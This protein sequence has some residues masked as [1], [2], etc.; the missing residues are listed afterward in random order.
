MLRQIHIFHNGEHIFNYSYALAFR[1]EDLSNI[2]KIIQS[3]I[4]MPIPDKTF[5]RT[6]SD[7]QL[8]YR[9]EPNLLFLFVTDLVDNLDY[10]DSIIKKTMN[11]FK[12]LF[13]E[14]E[15]FDEYNLQKEELITFLE[16]IQGDLHSKI[17][18]IG[19]TNS[20]KTKLFNL[21]KSNGEK[22]IM[23]FAVSSYYK[24]DKLCFDLWDFQLKDNFSLLWSKFIKGSDLIIFLFDLSNYHLKVINHFLS[25]QKQD[26][27]L[28]KLIII[29][30]KR[31]LVTDE[32]LKLIKNEID[33]VDFK[34]ISLK[35]PDAKENI[36]QIISNVLDLRSPLPKTF[37]GLKKEAED[38]FNEGN[39]VLAI[40]K[41]K[42]L[43]KICNEYQDFNYINS[44][45]QKLMDIQKKVDEQNKLRKIEE[46]R[47]K[48]QIPD[49]IRFTK[50]V[51]VK[52]LPQDVL[53]GISKEKVELPKIIPEETRPKIPSEK[54]EDLLLFN[55]EKKTK[56]P[57][58]STL[59]PE[60]IKVD[61]DLV[62]PH[63]KRPAPQEKL[64][65][66]EFSKELQKLI[67]KKGSS[68][69]LKLCDQLI[70]ELQKT[71][72]RPLTMDDIEMAADIFV[73]QERL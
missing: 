27:N 64:V 52:P 12:E 44:F 35:D 3:Y 1:D 16:K 40:T 50:K 48:F 33:M 59:K 54:T 61:L 4:D 51:Q 32:D 6:T 28:S 31:D 9:S 71:L 39:L 37:Y 11:K 60:D 43:I 67:E 5:Q 34:E 38:L 30:N 70:S 13:P 73:K 36:D 24:I 41:Y 47:K 65:E 15:K 68:L 46:S 69:N 10:I 55:K 8:F 53:E 25:L 17:A 56:K 62:V 29:G 45:K 58:K 14:P 21:L 72:N 19:P 49:R 23:N 2:K 57:P 22:P 66:F 7:Y 42:E 20:G 18:I 26:N 63:A